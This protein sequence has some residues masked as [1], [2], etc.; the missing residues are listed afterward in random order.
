MKKR[1]AL[2][3]VLCMLFSMMTTSTVAAS[4]GLFGSIFSP[5]VPD[6]DVAVSGDADGD[7]EVT[8]DDA[9]YVLMHTFFSDQYPENQDFDFDCDGEV[10]KDD[11]VYV[12]MH[13]F[14]QDEYPMPERTS[15]KKVVSIDIASMKQLS[16]ITGYQSV[17]NSTYTATIGDGT[18]SI[19]AGSIM[20][21]KSTNDALC[22]AVNFGSADLGIPIYDA[23]NNKMYMVWGDTFSTHGHGDFSA[24][25]DYQPSFFWNNMTLARSNDTTYASLADGFNISEFLTGTNVSGQPLKNGVWADGVNVSGR[26]ASPIDRITATGGSEISKLSTGGLII[27]GTIYLFYSSSGTGVSTTFHYSSCVKSTDGGKTWE[28]VHDLTWNAYDINDFSN[29]ATGKRGVVN[30][31]SYLDAVGLFEGN[32]AVGVSRVY[33][34][35]PNNTDITFKEENGE[36]Y[37]AFRTLREQN[38]RSF[39]LDLDN[40]VKASGS[41]KVQ[42]EFRPTDGFTL[43]SGKTKPLFLRFSEKLATGN[44]VTVYF[45]DLTPDANGWCTVEADFTSAV[46]TSE[47][48]V[49]TYASLGHGV[50]IKTIT[51]TDAKTGE[52]V[53]R[54]T[55]DGIMESFNHHTAYHFTQF[56]PVQDKVG[57][58]RYIYFY[59]Q[60]SY[61]EDDIYMARVPKAQLE[62]FDAYEYFAGRKA[63]GSSIWTKDPAEAQP[64]VEL[65][66]GAS[67]ISV[68]YNKGLGKWM[69]TYF[70]V[71]FGNRVRF[72]DTI[73]GEYT[74]GYTFISNEN[75][76]S[77]INYEPNAGYPFSNYTKGTYN[78][79]GAYVNSHWISEDGTSFYCILSQ[80]YD[81]YNVSLVKV[82]L[83]VEFEK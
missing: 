20:G 53:L 22:K 68:A 3:L 40:E 7:G 29:S 17:L 74:D 69:L 15:P 12:L 83:D 4:E 56:T 21:F 36:N 59:G 46:N 55:A 70:G 82:E 31:M 16:M 43:Q 11:A 76:T 37:L 44:D 79:Y 80:F 32:D 73:D 23:D 54:F 26:I 8:K 58:G 65:A 47:L 52:T 45:D 77:F 38:Y 33:T 57:N 13:T 18:Y 14:F 64:L 75:V 62:S 5:T 10:T 51:V 27:D 25:W 24:W 39:N 49:F 9:V 42:V 2:F 71:G 48:R 41:Y 19:P 30:Q 35:E 66:N 60:G 72:A 61:R 78:I 28:R 63:D 67:S 50:D 34:L 1:L 6:S 81:C